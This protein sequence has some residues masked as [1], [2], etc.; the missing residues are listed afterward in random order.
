MRHPSVRQPEYRGVVPLKFRRRFVLSLMLPA[1]SWLGACYRYAP[2]SASEIQPGVE[3]RARLSAVA[4]DRIRQG[5][6]AQAR[7]L[8]GFTARGRITRLSA[9][10]VVIGVER[11][12]LEANVRARTTS[13]DFALLRS[14]IQQ[15]EQRTLSRRRTVLTAVGLGALT[16][17]AVVIAVERGGRSTGTTPPPGGTPEQRMPQGIRISFP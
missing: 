1:F 11:M 12:E 2:I 7:M 8:Q 14:D 5:P 13:T 17:A 3:V 9:D 15:F 16:V 6:E 10:S 4:V